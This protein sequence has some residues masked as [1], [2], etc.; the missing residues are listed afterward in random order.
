MKMES[1]GIKPT[2]RRI[3]DSNLNMIK[4]HVKT[5]IVSHH[6]HNKLPQQRGLKQKKI[7][8]SSGGQTYEMNV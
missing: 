4:Y 7:I 8:C 3:N 6:Y 5:I 2:G 1:H